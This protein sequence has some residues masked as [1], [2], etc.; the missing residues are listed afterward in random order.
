[1]T[2]LQIFYLLLAALGLCTTM[3]FNVAYY[4]ERGYFDVMDFLQLAYASNVSTS[5]MNDVLVATTA[6]VCWLFVESRRIAMRHAWVFAACIF[7]AFAFA[8]PLYLFFRERHIA[9]SQ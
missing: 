2:P 6:F 7:V 9:N 1:M 8:F 4:N 5:I 3:F